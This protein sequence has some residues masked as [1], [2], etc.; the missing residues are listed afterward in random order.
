M[1]CQCLL[2]KLILQVPIADDTW[3]GIVS[4]I[5]LLSQILVLP[6]LFVDLLISCVP[7]REKARARGYGVRLRRPLV[8]WNDLATYLVLMA[9]TRAPKLL[10]SGSV[11]EWYTSDAGTT[12]VNADHSL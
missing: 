2:R 6:S 3:I 10:K 8:A 4:L 7:A 12:P 1:D 11:N 9:A 5:L